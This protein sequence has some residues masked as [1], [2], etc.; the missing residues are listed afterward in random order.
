MKTLLVR[1][2]SHNDNYEFKNVIAFVSVFCLLFSQRYKN[3]NTPK[4]AIVT[5]S[6]F[7]AFCPLSPFNGV[8]HCRNVFIIEML[9][10]K[11]M[12]DFFLKFQKILIFDYKL[13]ILPLQ[14]PLKM[15]PKY[16]DCKT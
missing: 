11:S 14:N 15:F 6:Y 9:Y 3:T 12:A 2:R 4:I 13:D 10:L 8:S 5:G 1:R 7:V 16:R